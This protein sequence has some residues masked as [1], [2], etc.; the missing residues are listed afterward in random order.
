[1]KL[2]I[3]LGAGLCCA[4]QTTP[5]RFEVASV[6]P[7]EQEWLEMRPRRSGGRIAWRTDL[8]HLVQYAYRLQAWRITG[9][10]P[11]EFIYDIEAVTAPSASDEQVRAML[12]A[13]V[14]ERFKM[15]SHRETK[16]AESY[17]LTAAPGGIRIKAV[18]AADPA[19]PLPEWAVGA[20]AEG[21]IVATLPEKG[22]TAVTGRRVGMQDLADGLQRVL[23]FNVVDKTGFAGDYYFAF[24]FAAPD[25]PIEAN[26]PSLSTAV[27]QLG[28]RIRRQKLPVE[29]LVIDSIEKLPTAN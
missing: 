8:P 9:R 2:W 20:E 23:Q 27:Q 15:A 14:A 12:R 16:V 18:Q 4:A 7:I 28:L 6:K 25:A 29:I 10:L 19:P 26:A 3:A 13:L 5:P 24:R 11:A 21:R 22:V 1:V 17:V